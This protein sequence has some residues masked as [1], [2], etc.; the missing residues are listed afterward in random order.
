M[1]S[2]HRSH[3][4]RFACVLLLP[5]AAACARDEADQAAVPPAAEPAPGA[6]PT[7]AAA[8]ARAEVPA[9]LRSTWDQFLAAWNG[10]DAGRLASFYTEDA[11]AQVGDSTYTGR[12][13]I[14]QRWLANALPTI[15]DLDAT[16]ENFDQRDNEI[17]SS[18]R[19]R[20][21]STAQGGAPQPGGGRYTA[22]W[23]RAPD[24]SWKVRSHITRSDQP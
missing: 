14:Q 20:L 10:D 11:V 6:Q 2:T 24:G 21:M 12:A 17:V 19:Y 15:S 5:L 16:P 18:G 13:A 3:V 22:T 9:E 7:T 23:T 8:G 4:L 1:T